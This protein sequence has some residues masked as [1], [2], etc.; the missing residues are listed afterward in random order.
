MANQ[1][2]EEDR[3]HRGDVLVAEA[4]VSAGE[5]GVARLDGFDPDIGDCRAT[6]GCAGGDARAPMGI[7][8][9][10]IT[11]TAITGVNHVASENLLG[12]G[13]R[14]RLGFNRGQKD[15]ALHARHV[16]LEE[17]AVLDD[18]PSN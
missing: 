7:T 3:S 13:H 14:P 16:E 11:P 1:L 18:L 9:T 10:A 12:Q 8:R 5:T 2:V 15:F 17:S 6:L 4:K